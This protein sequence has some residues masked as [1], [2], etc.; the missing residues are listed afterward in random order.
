MNGARH[1]DS[2]SEAEGRSRNET[3]ADVEGAS[4][5]PLTRWLTAGVIATAGLVLALPVYL[6][7][8]GLSEGPRTPD[9]EAPATFVGRDACITCHEKAYQAWLGSDHDRAME[10]ADET[11][12]RGDFNDAVFE[13]NGIVSRFYRRD[14]RFFVFTEGPGGKMQE[15]EITHTFG[16]EPLQQYLIPFPGGRMQALS[17]AWDT[18]RKTWF[19]LYPDQDIPPDD[20][21]HWTRNGQNWNGMCAECHS[22]NLVK[23]Y[24]ADTESYVTTWSEIDV[25]C[26][27]CH[28][29]GSRH[30][31]WAEMPE[32]ARPQVENYD[33]LIRSSDVTNKEYVEAC[34]PCHSRRT[35]LGDYD[36]SRSE[37]LDNVLPAVL[38]EGLYHADGQI[39]D[40]VY[41]YGS[42][43]QS[44]M[45]A[46]GVSCGD[47]HD[48]HTL[49]LRYEENQLCTQCHRADIYDSYDH[50]FHQDV[51]QGKPSD[52][53]LCVKCHMVERPYMVIDRRADHS[54][55]VPRP[56]LS[57][58]I[59]VPNACTQSGC[60]D[61]RPLSWSL[62]AYQ[63]WYGQARKP[64]F[65]QVFAAARSGEPEARDALI[66]IAGDPLYPAIARATALSLLAG[67]PGEEATRSF[68]L[69]LMDEDPL[70]RHTAIANAS[71]PTPERRSELL[72]PLLFDPVK[73]VRMEAAARLAD[74]PPESLQPYQSEA[75]ASGLAEYREAMEYSLDFAASAHNLG[76]LSARLGDAVEAERYYR[77][78]VGIDD[79]FIP[80][81]VN[82]ALL[83][84]STGRNPEAE[85][86]LRGVLQ[87]YPDQS[88]V[89]YNL[90]L[91][92]AEMDRMDEAVVFLRRA[93]E[94]L[95]ERAMVHYNYGLAAQSLGR[96]DE[97]ERALSRA[98][99]VEPDNPDF[100]FA[101][102]D[103][104]LRRGMP[105][106]AL[107]MADRL[108]EI[109]PGHP[110]GQQLK[111]AVEAAL[112]R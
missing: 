74:A 63:R 67:Y 80:A 94:G 49:K 1:P 68:N 51:Y 92:L 43:V 96:L 45:F 87:A 107:E 71:A 70:I 95:P 83:L 104:F 35:E 57:E 6:L 101:L 11:T 26:E 85:A 78:A 61:D 73:A 100:L 81:K 36:H 55:R 91:L 20:W 40:E 77:I 53:V 44:K 98:L 9:T 46:N 24:E 31:A 88:D 79:L 12:V 93:S 62:E 27:A 14:G 30:V 5:D 69:A 58:E 33:L 3:P 89:A 17:I 38:R 39:I 47:C 86:L 90:G 99:A 25:S 97:A 28:G 4:Q 65:G 22:T 16:W 7:R 72:S 32:M 34:A 54:L 102:A 103:H 8:Q 42:F 23:G 59:G 56:D 19:Y 108:L 76:N 82:L 64:H 41:V 105:T 10:V 18:E 111:A 29:P 50:H 109:S 13:R 66:Q 75:L 110:R 48:P 37:L 15:F 106:R 60:H 2:A 21:L 84:N 112:R 52:G